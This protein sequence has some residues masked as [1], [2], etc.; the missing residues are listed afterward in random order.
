[1]VNFFRPFLGCRVVVSSWRRRGGP[2]LRGVPGGPHQTTNHVQN[3]DNR[4]VCQ[5]NEYKLVV[6]LSDFNLYIAG[7]L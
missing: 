3:Q 7:S 5:L 6:F 2:R 1:M 4:L